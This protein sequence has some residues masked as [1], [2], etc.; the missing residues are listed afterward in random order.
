MNENRKKL[1]QEDQVNVLDKIASYR[2]IHDSIMELERKLKDMQEIKEMLVTDLEL[3]RADEDMLMA[4]LE[5]KYGLGQ[6]DIRNM[7]WVEKTIENNEYI[8]RI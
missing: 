6:L 8:E 3:A 4:N 1:E 5:M 7:E 2:A